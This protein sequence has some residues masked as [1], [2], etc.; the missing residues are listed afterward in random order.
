MPLFLETN[1]VAIVEMRFQSTLVLAFSALAV[2]GHVIKRDGESVL[3]A[4]HALDF[5]LDK[6]SKAVLEFPNIPYSKLDEAGDATQ[7]KLKELLD[8]VTETHPIGRLESDKIAEALE[9]QVPIIKSTAEGVIARH[10]QFSFEDKKH[11][12]ETIREDRKLT[13][14]INEILG[15]KL[16]LSRPEHAVKVS[17]EIDALFAQAEAKFS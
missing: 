6:Q 12:G 4:I 15:P 5:A 3:H 9:A 17:E 2:S 7:D 1:D 11:V 10:H 14:K 8:V 13:R 16:N